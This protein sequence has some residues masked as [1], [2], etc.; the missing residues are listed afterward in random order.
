MRVNAT[1]TG[2]PKDQRCAAVLAAD[3]A[4][5]SL[6]VHPSLRNLV[7]R[8]SCVSRCE[9]RDCTCTEVTAGAPACAAL[10]ANATEGLCG[11][12]LRC[13]A[14]CADNSDRCRRSTPNYNECRPSECLPSDC[15]CICTRTVMDQA[16][17]SRCGTCYTPSVLF[18]YGPEGLHEVTIQQRCSMD[19]GGCVVAFFDA[20]PLNRTVG[21]TFNPQR[22]EEAVVGR[23]TA[24]GEGDWPQGVGAT[25]RSVGGLAAMYTALA[26]LTWL[27]VCNCFVRRGRH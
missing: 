10:I 26:L 16:C 12:G 8:V 2:L 14:S 4:A 11:A 25:Y 27:G 23:S 19:D 18:A 7:V 15:S 13:C 20:W 5:G 21:G 22:P 17:T 3:V 24:Y 9:A 6:A 1:R